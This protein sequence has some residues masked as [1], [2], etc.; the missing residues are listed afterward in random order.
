MRGRGRGTGTRWLVLLFV[1]S[2]PL[3]VPRVYATDEVQYFAFARSALKDGDF[4]FR[5]E[6]ER[7]TA[8]GSI[9]RGALLGVPLSPT[10]RVLSHGTAGF[11]V[12]WA[13]WFAIGE[14]VARVGGWPAD[15]YSA[16]YVTAV[17]YGV[18]L[19]AFLALLMLRSV[20]L[21]FAA[22]GPVNRATVAAWWATALPFYMYVTPPMAHATSLF[23]ATL[24]VWL[25]YRTRPFPS[26]VEAAA[27]GLAGGLAVALRE[28]NAIFFLLPAVDLAAGA[29]GALRT[30]APRF[31]ALAG[32]AAGMA[33]GAAVGFLPQLLAWRALF[34]SFLPPGE[35][36]GYLEGGPV[37]LLSV[38]LS[39]HRGLLPWHPVWLLGIIGL[40]MLARAR[41]RIGWPLLAVFM[42]EILTFASV[43][44]WS[45]GMAFG[46]RRLLVCLFVVLLGLTEL[47]RRWPRPAATATV[48][49]L[50]WLNLSLL[51]QFGT[52][53]IPR[54]GEVS[55]NR[56]VHNH[57]VEVPRRAL[58]IAGRYLLDRERLHD[59]ESA[60]RGNPLR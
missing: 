13:P 42:L 31:P 24:F 21:D 8:D 6:F 38:L 43:A 56:I 40:V 11:V 45:G 26:A 49:V 51:L 52:G 12:L 28:T 1:L 57:L 14:V 2:L 16:P 35:R 23:A 59:R 27:L 44:N 10:G 54:Q 5:N 50:V 60:E 9:E 55:W 3:V 53:M 41:P 7:L 17:G 15:G 19:Y 4:D 37:H 34:G 29:L 32:R 46:Q 39:P 36:T 25:W 30:G 33:A 20:A 47:F 58:G 18:A 48:A 22:P